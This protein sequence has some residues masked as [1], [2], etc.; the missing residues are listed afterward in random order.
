MTLIEKSPLLRF[1]SRY[2]TNVFM[3][4]LAFGQRAWA[5]ATKVASCGIGHCP[6]TPE[7]SARTGHRFSNSSSY[8]HVTS[9]RP[10]SRTE[11]LYEKWQ[12]LHGSTS[13]WPTNSK[14]YLRY[15]RN[16]FE[17]R[18]QQTQYKLSR[19]IYNTLLLCLSLCYENTPS[20]Y[21]HDLFSWRLDLCSDNVLW[22]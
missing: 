17:Y 10:Y 12:G 21:T 1:V 3:E 13:N 20:G 18:R 9:K 19:Y 7:E 2:N 5:D 8:S 6:A 11:V 22:T 15:L 14:A 16:P 4:F